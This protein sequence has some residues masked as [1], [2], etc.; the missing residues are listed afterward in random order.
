MAGRVAFVGAVHEALPAL[1]A[2]AEHPD[3]ELVCVVTLSEAGAAKASGVV[4]LAPVA[5]GA[6]VDLLRY[7]DVNS[8]EAVAGR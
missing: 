1:R 7:D 5:A 8:P 4:D 6:G 2:V 3:A